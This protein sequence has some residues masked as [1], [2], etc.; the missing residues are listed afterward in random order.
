[1]DITK[2]SLLNFALHANLNNVTVIRDAARARLVEINAVGVGFTPFPK[3]TV[4]GGDFVVREIREW[5]ATVRQPQLGE[6][7]SNKAIRNRLVY[8]VEILGEFCETLQA[9]ISNKLP[10]YTTAAR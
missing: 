9:R 1:V 4:P 3:A 8:Q 10:S 5:I 2:E 7:F 6:E